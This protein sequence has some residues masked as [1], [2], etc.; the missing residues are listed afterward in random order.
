MVLLQRSGTVGRGVTTAGREVTRGRG[1]AALVV[2]FVVA[3]VVAFVVALVVVFTIAGV[4]NFR[5]VGSEIIAKS[6]ISELITSFYQ[7]CQL[8]LTL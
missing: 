4:C 5:S 6:L 3:L 7:I 8:L 1:V 2:A